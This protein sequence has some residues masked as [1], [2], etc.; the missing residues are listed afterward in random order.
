M[1]DEDFRKLA[2]DVEAAFFNHDSDDGLAAK[3]LAVEAI[4]RL[5]KSTSKILKHREL[6]DSAVMALNLAE[7][8]EAYQALRDH[9][10]AETT[11][12][13]AKSDRAAQIKKAYDTAIEWRRVVNL[14]A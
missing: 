10:I 3:E 1:T 5:N 14:R 6:P 4:N 2:V 9:H 11:V 8:R 12:L 13:V 7:L